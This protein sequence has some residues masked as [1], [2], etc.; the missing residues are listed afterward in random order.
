M[1]ICS[2][3]FFLISLAR[4]R[5]RAERSHA[6][7]LK[8][9]GCININFNNLIYIYLSPGRPSSSCCFDPEPYC[10]QTLSVDCSCHRSMHAYIY[11]IVYRIYPDMHA[12]MLQSYSIADSSLQG[13]IVLQGFLPRFGR[14][15][16]GR[17][18]KFHKLQ[19]IN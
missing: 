15:H 8:F 7:L 1:Y 19:N 18:C 9:K 12:C 6:I 16:R 11:T 10:C 2:L 5:D 4:S 13:S 17:P 3:L 14:V